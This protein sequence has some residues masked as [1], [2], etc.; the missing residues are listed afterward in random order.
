MT[1]GAPS[2]RRWAIA[3][4]G[5]TRIAIDADRVESAQAAD[6]PLEPLPRRAGPVAGLLATPQGMV[7]AVDI[8]RWLPMPGAPPAGAPEDTSAAGDGMRYLILAQHGR[9][10][11]IR[12]D[13]LLGIEQVPASRYQRMH[14]VDAPQE[15]FDGVLAEPGDEPPAL[16]LEPDRL[17]ALLNLWVDSTE[18]RAPLT[19]AATLNHLTE[20]VALFRVAGQV[21]AVQSR[22]VVELM[23]MPAA[24][25]AFIVSAATRHFVN[26]RDVMTPLLNTG[27]V[28]PWAAPV[29]HPALAAVLRDDAG[30][31][32]MLPVD[33]LLAHVPTPAQAAEVDDGAPAW[34]GGTWTSDV[35]VARE[36]RADALLAALPE[37]ALRKTGQRTNPST[38]R[39]TNEHAHV[40]LQAGTSFAVP[41]HEVLAILDNAA[42]EATTCQWRGQ[43]IAVRQLGAAASGRLLALVQG[44][45]G[46]IALRAERLVALLPAHT[47]ESSAYPGR[48]GESMLTIR[49]P[50]ASYLVRSA[51]QLLRES[52]PAADAGGGPDVRR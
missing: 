42:G 50:S 38:A 33:E 17:M 29:G 5:T 4:I 18:A 39:A 9:R 7:P 11:G 14:H 8:P 32:A 31:H 13:D 34:W 45:S 41:L 3:R 24:P 51:A 21:V 37:A 47:A 27:W 28:M 49:E 16:V 26:W 36:L 25:T 1:D 23:P 40:V 35:G 6:R 43:T 44:D 12:V 30:R 52:R 15:L 10:V 22:R 2:T 19:T 46:Y 20:S 48:P